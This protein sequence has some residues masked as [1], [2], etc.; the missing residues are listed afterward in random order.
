MT[1]M[2]RFLFLLIALPVFSSLFLFLFTSAA[3]AEY[4]IILKNGSVIEG[5]GSYTR[6]DGRIEFILEGGTVG[7]PLKDISKI[8]KY[9][10]EGGSVQLPSY[11]PPKENTAPK[12]GTSGPSSGLSAGQ[13]K[14]LE[15]RLAQINRRLAKIKLTEDEYK[16]LEDQYQEVMLRIQNLFNQG[17]QNAIAAG[18]SPLVANQQYIQFLTPEQRQMVQLNFLSKQDLEEKIKD[19]ETNILPPLKDEKR[20]LLD[21]K[22][23]V[24][25]QL[26]S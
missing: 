4:R 8:Q 23:Q 26:G 16:K 18:K 22:Q 13:K 3:H 17:R 24:E 11:T 10:E 14:L 25:D 1:P 19:M 2:K 20:R 6:T 7:I 15:D 12:A 21:E 9:G 5:I